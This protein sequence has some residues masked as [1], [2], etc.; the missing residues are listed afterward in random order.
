MARLIALTTYVGFV[1]RQA[2]AMLARATPLT[3]LTGLPDVARQATGRAKS[4]LATGAVAIRL[5]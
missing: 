3:T 2:G 5:T 4:L 1:T